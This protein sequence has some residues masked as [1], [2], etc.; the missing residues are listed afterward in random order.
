M[1]KPQKRKF[2]NQYARDWDVETA[3]VPQGTNPGRR[4]RF[5]PPSSDRCDIQVDVAD[6]RQ[7]HDLFPVKHAHAGRSDATS[8]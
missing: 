1:G 2:V 7:A 8:C 3:N 5:T 6:L 4:R